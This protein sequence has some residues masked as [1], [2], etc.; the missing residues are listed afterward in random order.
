MARRNFIIV[1]DIP[2]FGEKVQRIINTYYS[3]KDNFDY[4]IRPFLTED[5]FERAKKYITKE[6][7]NIDII[8]SDQNLAP[9]KG[10]D[11]FKICNISLPTRYDNVS[12]VLHIYKVMHSNDDGRLKQHQK[13]HFLHYD[14][15]INSESKDD[16]TFFLNEYERHIIDVKEKGNPNAIKRLYGLAGYKEILGHEIT[17]DKQPVRIKDILLIVMDKTKG[18]SDYFHFY[19]N[20]GTELAQSIESK[21]PNHLF[22]NNINALD[23]IE[24]EL[25]GAQHEKFKINPLWYSSFDAANEIIKLISP[26]NTQLQ[27]KCGKF[28]K[29]ATQYLSQDLDRFFL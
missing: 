13:E 27:L 16:I 29:R 24:G 3:S 12:N 6:Y 25:A 21:K 22:N 28:D 23:F 4:N 2:D 1:D 7:Y 5:H 8:F 26:Y 15:F 10:T 20:N 14:Y 18:K 11:L 17:I 9:G 19:Y